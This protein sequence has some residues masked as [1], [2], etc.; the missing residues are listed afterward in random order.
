MHNDFKKHVIPVEYKKENIK[1]EVYSRPLL[2]W[3]L[4]LLDNPLLVS[5]FICKVALKKQSLRPVNMSDSS[6]HDALLQDTLHT[7]GSGLF[8]DHMFEEVKTHAKVLGCAAEKMI[9]NWFDAFLRWQNLNHFDCITNISFSDSNKF[10]DISENVLTC[11]DDKAGYA[12]LKCIASYLHVY[13]TIAAGEAEILVF[14]E[15]LDQ[16]IEILGDKAT[17]NWDFFQRLTP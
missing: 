16:Y 9:D 8:G 15:C 12:L 13:I 2:D 10:L 4:D 3:A 14:Q 11:K 17:K 6:P 7:Y 5:H 1:Y